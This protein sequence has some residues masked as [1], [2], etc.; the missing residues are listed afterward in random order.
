MEKGVNLVE[1]LSGFQDHITPFPTRRSFIFKSV[2]HPFN[3]HN[4]CALIT[5]LV[6]DVPKLPTAVD[7]GL[8]LR[9]Q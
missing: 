5:Q 7:G 2:N 4:D 1:H 9:G 6:V 8:Q 3:H